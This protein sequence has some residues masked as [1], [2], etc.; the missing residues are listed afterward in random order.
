[1]IKLTFIF[2]ATFIFIGFSIKAQNIGINPTGATPNSSA[3]LDVSATDK[4]MLIP[5]VS[6]TSTSDVTTIVNP[7]TSLLVYNTN[8]GMS[9][10]SVGFY[11]W[12]GTGWVK[13][14][15]GNASTSNGLWTA[16]GNDISNA[17]SGNVGIGTAT[18]T[19]PLH[20]TGTKMITLPDGGTETSNIT[21]MVNDTTPS[22]TANSKI[23]IYALVKNHNAANVGVLAEATTKDSANNFA[24]L[25][26]LLGGTQSG[27]LAYAIGA[28]DATPPSIDPLSNKGALF[29]S[30]NTR[31]TGVPN[32]N[33]AGTIITNAGNG[34]MQWSKQLPTIFMLGDIKKDTILSNGYEKVYFNSSWSQPTNDYN[35]AGIYNFT[36]G[37]FTIT[38]AGMYNLTLTYDYWMYSSTNIGRIYS[39]IQKNGSTIQQITHK[40]ISQVSEINNGFGNILHLYNDNQFGSGETFSYSVVTY[41]GVGDKITVIHEND[42]DGNHYIQPDNGSFSGFKIR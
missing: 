26:N 31:Y 34:T 14:N 9:N 12:N 39:A 1:M 37:E 40:Y 2:L 25:G 23:G 18:P 6:L 8:A 22:T 16:N 33:E 15:D 24:I 11:Y 21:A 17:N 5:R 7:A 10:G 19:T 35:L 30:G 42:T 28:V 3:M 36:T 41:L 20:I 13:L 27:N 29:I 38:E 32:A 4:G